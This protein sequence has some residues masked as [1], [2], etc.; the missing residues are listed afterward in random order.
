MTGELKIPGMK[1]SLKAGI[2]VLFLLWGFGCSTNIPVTVKEQSMEV[3]KFFSHEN[4]E[5]V[6]KTFVDDRGMVDYSGLRKDPSDL[7]KYYFLLSEYSPDSHPGLF[8]TDQDRLAYWI[9]A[10]NAAVIKTLLTYYP[11]DSVKDI[12]PPLPFFFLPRKSGFFLF[13]KIRIGGKDMS[14]YTMENRIIRKRF[15]D[16]RIHFAL[17]CASLGCPRLRGNPFVPGA[18]NQQLDDAAR[19]FISEKRNVG[20]DHEK[21]TITLSSIYKWYRKDFIKWYQGI[22]PDEKATLLKY[23]SIYLSSDK[24]AEINETTR[25]YSIMFNPYDWHLNDQ[26]TTRQ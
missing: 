20:I 5:R 13:Q 4:F 7:D 12:K 19:E 3:P 8:P 11:V 16:P 25:A 24:K 23:V 9:N 26:K 14:L 10:Y 1:A 21:E 6:L 2:A 22:Y 17:N 15:N 18:L